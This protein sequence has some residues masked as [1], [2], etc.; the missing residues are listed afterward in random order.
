MLVRLTVVNALPQT[1]AG[2]KSPDCG[3]LN[4]GSV[5]GL[6]IGHQHSYPTFNILLY[7]A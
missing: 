5:T 4:S 6:Y 7:L 2:F 1:K 3:E